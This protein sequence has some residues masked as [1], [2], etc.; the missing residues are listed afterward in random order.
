MSFPKSPTKVGAQAQDV[1]EN[2]IFST[3][4]HPDGV[5]IR[6]PCAEA[7]APDEEPPEDMKPGPLELRY[8]CAKHGDGWCLDDWGT[9]TVGREPSPG[10]GSIL[11]A[12]TYQE[13][14]DEL[15]AALE[16]EQSREENPAVGDTDT[17]SETPEEE[18]PAIVSVASVEQEESEEDENETYNKTVD[19]DEDADYSEDDDD[20]SWDTLPGPL[21]ISVVW[22]SLDKRIARCF[23]ILICRRIILGMGSG[24]QSLDYSADDIRLSYKRF[25]K[26]FEDWNEEERST[27]IPGIPEDYSNDCFSMVLHYPEWRR[28]RLERCI[29]RELRAAEWVVKRLSFDWD[30]LGTTLSLNWNIANVPEE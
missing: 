20:Q 27:I 16:G 19:D 11:F 2:M 4:E 15:A 8:R 24:D 22:K 26:V 13:T 9:C 29:R 6:T 5:V 17:N 12:Q 7:A 18:N 25:I 28:K 10:W 14:C 3:E 1:P 23:S 21:E 30:D